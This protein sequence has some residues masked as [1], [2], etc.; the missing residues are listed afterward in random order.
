MRR[1]LDWGSHVNMRC[2]FTSLVVKKIPCRWTSNLISIVEM[3]EKL[4][5]FF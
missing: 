5:S 3:H 4:S 1:A 2:D